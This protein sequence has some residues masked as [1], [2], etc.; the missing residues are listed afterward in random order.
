MS[1]ALIERLG[2]WEAVCK[3]Y[4]DKTMKGEDFYKWMVLQKTYSPSG[5]VKGLFGDINF[6]THM[7]MIYQ[8]INNTKQHHVTVVTG[9][10]GK[11]KSTLGLQAG[12]IT[13]PTFDMS[14]VCYVPYQFFK[15][16]PKLK[17]GQAILIDEG[18][19]FFG[20]KAHMTKLARHLQ[21]AFDIIRGM[22]LHII[23]C[24][25]K[26]HKLDPTIRDNLVDTILLKKVNIRAKTE[27]EKYRYYRGFN[28]AG[29]GEA[30]AQIAK[31]AMCTLFNV[32]LKKNAFWN[33]YHS[34]EI[35][36]INDI[37]EATY[38]ENKIKYT[39]V[40]FE[41]LAEEYNDQASTMPELPQAVASKPAEAEQ[42]ELEEYLGS[43]AV[44]KMFGVLQSTVVKWGKKGILKEVKVGGRHMYAKSA[45]KELKKCEIHTMT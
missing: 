12:A 18:G 25:P 31:Q 7:F 3:Y 24:F 11:G 29:I 39:Q 28:H 44:A 41:E 27:H 5:Y 4:A 42:G 17:R 14:R 22:G 20:S 1:Q 16:V 15:T 26:Y 9:K 34:V 38:F 8:K 43:A 21:E 36:L 30:N 23:I 37:N 10:V 32:K 35:P 2:S 33:G 19:R 45:L 6:Y 40:R 13:D